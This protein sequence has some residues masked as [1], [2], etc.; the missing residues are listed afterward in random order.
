MPDPTDPAPRIEIL[1]ALRVWLGD[2]E[3][4]AGPRQQRCLLA[5][6]LALEGRPLG[7]TELVGLLWGDDAP[8][9]AVNVIHKY[10]GALR[11]MLEP[12]L[13]PRST[14]S[15]LLRHGS[16]YLFSLGTAQ[17]DLSTFRTLVA[18]ATD[19]VAAGRP[20][21]ALDRY[22]EALRLWHGPAGDSLADSA[23]ATAAFA[24]IDGEFQDAAIAAAAVANTLVQ[25]A[26][27]LAALRLAASMG[28]F[29]EP[30]HAGLMIALA[31]AGHQAE[32]LALYRTIRERLADEL[33]IDPGTE[34]QAAHR[35]VL[36]QTVA[37]VFDEPALD[38]GRLT[39]RPIPPDQLPRPAQLPPDQPM[40]TGRTAELGT[41]RD[42]VAARDPDGRGGPL[43]VALDGMAGVG[44]ST[45]AVHFAHEVADLF[46]DGQLALDLRGHETGQEALTTLLYG[47]GVPA[48]QVP[49]TYDARLGAFRSHTADK[50]I[51]LLLDDALDADQV[52]PLVPASPGSMVLVTSRR[53]LVELAAHDGAHL[54]R[55][56]PPDP[57]AARDLLRRRLSAAP[58]RAAEMDAAAGDAVE[59]ILDRSGRLP[60]ALALLAARLSARPRLTLAAV[61]AELAGGAA[62]LDAFP[63]GEH[64]DPRTSFVRSYHELAP[65]AAHLFRL[66]CVPPAAGVSV[67]ACASLSGQPVAVTRAQLGELCEAALINED[68]RG[69]FSLHVLL[70]AYAAELFRSTDPEPERSEAISR[71]LQYYLYSSVHAHA[72]L[73][74]HDPPVTLPP[75]L[76]GVLAEQ[77]STRDAAIRWFAAEYD[78]LRAAVRH[79][80]DLGYGIVPWH[81]AL[82]MQPYFEQSGHFGDW[83]QTTRTA[84][85]AA[86]EQHDEA[87]EEHILRNLT[88][89]RRA[90]GTVH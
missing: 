14:G 70:K 74:P 52:R 79:A 25:D 78:A 13:A 76:P 22:T 71:L 30:V 51:L 5:V 46:T 85:R 36:T 81:L 75:A 68:G 33:G 65:G 17:L 3:V 61:A 67:G 9:S 1:G 44:K 39:D 4:D 18:A 55:V 34:L 45:L 80:A 15:Y 12:G 57:A 59:V 87:G 24:S 43:I 19:E 47:L 48:R 38:P 50:R 49:G 53:P 89:A 27:V 56:E 66:L 8:A 16:A 54:L 90:L 58:N 28:R 86:R 64:G 41:L 42:L 60:L 32:A 73:C 11:R 21:A 26:R 40:F 20:D 10:V 23:A 2:T 37:P 88:A 69:R 35:R 7:V 77:P 84:L 82:A 62:T 72:L 63:T 6:F 31:A 83:E 29:H